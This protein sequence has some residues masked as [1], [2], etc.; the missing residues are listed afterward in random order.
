MRFFVLILVFFAIST[1]H[2]QPII[3]IKDGQKEL[4]IRRDM[5]IY[6]E[7]NSFHTYEQ[8]SQFNSTQFQGITEPIGSFFPTNF[9]LKLIVNNQS[10]EDAII[11]FLPSISDSI[12]LYCS[13]SDGTIDKLST[14]QHFPFQ[15]RGILNTNQNLK[16]TGSHNTNQVYYIYITS[17]FPINYKIRIATHSQMS[18]LYHY[19]GI[20]SGLLFGIII[21][22]IL[23]SFVM[24]IALKKPPYFWYGLYLIS[25]TFLISFYYGQFQEFIFPNVP[26]YNVYARI[27]TNFPTLLGIVFHM[28]FLKVRKNLPQYY[29]ISLS[30]VI[31]FSLNIF[32]GLIGFLDLSI[33]MSHVFSV[34]S[35]IYVI[36]LSLKLYTRKN[37]AL[38]LMILGTISLTGTIGIYIIDNLILTPSIINIK[39]IIHLG[40]IIQAFFLTLAM[41]QQVREIMNE[42]EKTKLQ[43]INS[44]QE[45]KELIRQ[46]NIELEKRIQDRTQEL[47]KALNREKERES[48][49]MRSNKELTEFAHIVSHDLKAPL[50]NIASFSQIIARKTHDRLDEREKEYM[51]YVITGAKQGTQ[52]VDDLLNYSKL[53]KNIGDPLPIDLNEMLCNIITNNAQILKDKNAEIISHYLPT[54]HAH[55]SLISLLWQNIILNGL[56]YND[57]PYPYI[58]VGVFKEKENL[59]FWIRDN[60][61]GIPPQYQEEVFRMFRRLHT[62]DKYEG[63]GIGLAFCKRIVDFYEGKIWFE[64]IEEC[65]TTFFFTIPKINLKQVE[66]IHSIKSSTPSVLVA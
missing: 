1:T 17:R 63:T 60:G 57:N 10:S 32:I 49:L 9:W 50:R 41:A 65:G 31:L 38:L 46:Q 62:S 14:G 51:N 59:V 11:D 35:G 61:I 5:L 43:Y 18:E 39:F 23:I 6:V 22:F 37:I 16:L 36:Y 64:S 12:L 48:Q 2:A 20:V 33:F 47:Q 54:I 28:H 26:Q 13:K 15:Q 3:F 34:P 66:D 55:K 7:N 42:K 30:L 25:L 40:M 45:T 21:A 56:K 53:D 44:L 19:D 24:Y 27:L 8:V 58:E 52:L 4:D 29:K